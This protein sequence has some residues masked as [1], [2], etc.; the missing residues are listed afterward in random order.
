VPPYRLLEEGKVI[1]PVTAEVLE[2]GGQ[3]VRIESITLGRGKPM[4][5]K[6]EELT[7]VARTITM[8]PQLLEKCHLING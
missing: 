8:Q 4:T 5:G 1:P 6:P 7:L 3:T 2:H